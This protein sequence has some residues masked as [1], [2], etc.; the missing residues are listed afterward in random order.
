M[1]ADLESL[2]AEQLDNLIQMAAKEREKREPVVATQ[3][4]QTAQAVLNPS[5]HVA[6]LPAGTLFQVRHSGFGWLSFV[7]P[8]A[9]RVMLLTALLNHAL[10]PSQQVAAANHPVAQERVRRSAR[11]REH[12]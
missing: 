4:P 1:Q 3:A 12:G 7:V 10:M 5:W 11:R 2:T 9:E 8:P 6:A